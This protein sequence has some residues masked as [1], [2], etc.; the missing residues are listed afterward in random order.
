MAMTS[1]NVAPD[2]PQGETAAN[3]C[4][5]LYLSEEQCEAL[6]VSGSID[7]GTVIG[8]TIRAVVTRSTTSID[9]PSEGETDDKDVS[10]CL[11]ITDAEITAPP[12]ATSSADAAKTLYGSAD[13]D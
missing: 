13:A 6:G 5:M 7:A 3:Y 10:L 4:P 1:L 11:S 12:K 9:D 8:M 2:Y